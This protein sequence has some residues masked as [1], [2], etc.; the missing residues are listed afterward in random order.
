MAISMAKAKYLLDRGS[1]S[2]V[3]NLSG[4]TS[5]A[6]SVMSKTTSGFYPVDPAPPTP[7]WPPPPKPPDQPNLADL[8]QLP[9][10]LSAL[11][12]GG[13]G[14]GP[15]GP[16][17]LDWA[18]YRLREKEVEHRIQQDLWERQWKAADLE[19]QRYRDLRDAYLRIGEL[20]LA[21]NAQKRADYWEGQK[22]ALERERINLENQGQQLQFYA[23]MAELEAQKQDSTNRFIIGMANAQNDAE[24]TRLEAAWRREQ[25]QIARMQ[26][27]TQRALG[28]WQARTAQ[29][30]AETERQAAL[31]NLGLEINKFIADLARSPRD[32][33]T[34]W[35]MQRGIAPDWSTIAS[36]GTPATGQALAPV[37]PL[38]LYTPTTQA[39]TF[40]M[41]STEFSQVGSHIGSYTPSPNP[42][43]S[44]GPAT[45]GSSAPPGI[46]MPTF[47]PYI[48]TSPPSGPDVSDINFRDLIP[49]EL[50]RIPEP[51]P[52]AAFGGFTNAPVILVGDSPGE[53]PDKDARPELV[54]NP[55]LAPIKV[56]P[57]KETAMMLA[58]YGINVPY[59]EVKEAKGGKAK[60]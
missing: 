48:D 58:K 7:N 38:T 44:M 1:G 5:P 51:I 8:L 56:V 21:Q 27:E 17:E 18:L 11:G 28:E 53:D 4:G 45:A 57:N 15:S 14:G 2:A 9:L 25:A 12:G 33:A 32:F 20:E 40:N 50:M 24:R 37:N 10:L 31:G 34:L 41:P 35:F 43:L 60:K 30:R 22:V 26:E 29:F 49:P 46:P 42:W 47:L 36:G 54:V 13:G 52:T 16:T 23:R 19:A 55:M 6:P 59:I 39:P 3:R